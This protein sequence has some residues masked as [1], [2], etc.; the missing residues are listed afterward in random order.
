MYRQGAHSSHHQEAAITRSCED[1]CSLLI[2]TQ[3]T[4]P[5]PIDSPQSLDHRPPALLPPCCIACSIVYILA[6]ELN[7]RWSL[8]RKRL[9]VP[10]WFRRRMMINVQFHQRC[11][12]CKPPATTPPSPAPTAPPTNR[13]SLTRVAVEG[14]VGRRVAHQRHHR[15]ADAVERPGGRPRALQDVKADLAG[16]AV[17]SV[18]HSLGCLDVSVGDGVG[19][20]AGCRDQTNKGG[21]VGAAEGRWRARE[22]ARQDAGGQQRTLKWT[23]GWKILVR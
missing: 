3:P 23:L 5:T 10:G 17:A 1:A 4:Q 19:W 13:P 18:E 16:L 21:A 12:A 20:S 22:G 15:L 2:N 8:L 9:P 6:R 7:P 11:T 14:A